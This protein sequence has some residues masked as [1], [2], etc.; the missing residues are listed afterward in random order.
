LPPVVPY[1]KV[2][3]TPLESYLGVVILRDQIEKIIEK[4]V[5]LV[6][7]NSID[8]LGEA[9]VDVNGFPASHSY[10]ELACGMRFVQS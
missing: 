10:E 8:A 5:R 2:V 6:F 4:Q 9:L 3:G 1:R 7:S